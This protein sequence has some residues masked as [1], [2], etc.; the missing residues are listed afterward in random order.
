MIYSQGPKCFNW[1]HW[2]EN[3]VDCGDSK[4]WK[5]YEQ[6]FRSSLQNT[7]AIEALE[8]ISTYE[9]LVTPE[10]EAAPEQNDRRLQEG[11]VTSSDDV[12]TGQD[13]QPK[14]E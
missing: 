9:Q 12:S 8:D 13:A 1:A 5:L 14:N 2:P 10:Q 4:I 7:L 11:G 6:M 3:P